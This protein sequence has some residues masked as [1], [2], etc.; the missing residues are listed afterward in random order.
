MSSSSS[1]QKIG[2]GSVRLGYWAIRGLAQ[3]IRYLLVYTKT[4]FVDERYQCGPPPNF[5]RSS[6]IDVKST[7][8]LTF[9]NLPYYFDEEVSLTQSHT[10][11]RHI[12]RKNKLLGDSPAAMA[13]I[14]NYLDEL[15]DIGNEIGGMC[16]GL[17]LSDHETAVSKKFCNKTGSLHFKLKTFSTVLGQN[18]WL[19]NNKLSVADFLFHEILTIVSDM[20]GDSLNDF[21][22]L[23]KYI[24][25]FRSLENIAAYIASPNHLV[26]PHNNMM[27]IWK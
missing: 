25:R 2:S 9:P 11:L 7:L 20:K 17:S 14:D 1:L 21:P 3:P 4:E 22:N 18:H 13:R 15:K 19:E 12:A 26:R 16:Y 6:W 23:T 27:A 24:E 10:I 5:D 8:P